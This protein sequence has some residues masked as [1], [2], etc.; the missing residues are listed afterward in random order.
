MSSKSLFI[1]L[2]VCLILIGCDSGTDDNELKIGIV[3]PA[4][5]TI[6]EA[7]EEVSK[8]IAL[9]LDEVLDSGLLGNTITSASLD[10][11]STTDG[12]TAA[13]NTLIN[14]V[15]TPVILGPVTSSATDA[16]I[17]IADGAGVVAFSPTSSATG[18]SAKSDWLFRSSLTV[19]QLVPV[20]IEVSKAH[21]NYRRV[22]TI[23]NS[24][25]TF[26]MSSNDKITE[27]LQAD[28]DITIVSA[29]SY[30]RPPGT[31]IG[32]LTTELTA[33]MNADPDAIFLSGLPEDH[34]GIL[35]QGHILGITNTPYIATLFAI[36]DVQRINAEVPGAAEGAV[37]FQVWLESS[38]EPLSREFVNSYT[39]R[40]GEAPSDYAARGYAA[41]HILAEALENAENYEAAS[42]RSALAAVKNLDTIYGP[43]S[44]DGNGD[45]MYNPVVAQ[46]RDNAFVV[47][48][49]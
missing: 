14:D 4:T 13:Y 23:V 10:N 34:F 16:I 31:E 43:F 47:L 39:A 11:K 40:H 12:S 26:S 36:N 29:Q 25:D 7:G 15:G 2:C 27:V 3:L 49:Q 1:G 37:T 46:V 48:Q 19:D 24:G 33:V 18:L 30:S 17:S 5:G 22:A 6:S 41:F 32:D 8:G 45:A 21:L 9:A 20:G 35:T 44:F 42:I 28:P 38:D